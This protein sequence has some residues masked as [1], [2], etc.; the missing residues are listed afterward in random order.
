MEYLTVEEI[1]LILSTGYK[2][3]GIEETLSLPSQEGELRWSLPRNQREIRFSGLE[4]PGEFICVIND[5]SGDIIVLHN[6]DYNG[7]LTVRKLLVIKELFNPN[8]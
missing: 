2:S 8:Y 7:P 5:S 4:G 3:R 1:K 6:G